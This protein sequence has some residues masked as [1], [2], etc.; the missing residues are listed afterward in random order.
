MLDFKTIEISKRRACIVLTHLHCCIAELSWGRMT[1]D[2]E[3]PE[4]A[5][6][7]GSHSHA[8]SMGTCGWPGEDL[9]S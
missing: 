9:I 6:D 5:K 8:E 4:L 1:K 7:A 3:L 2:S